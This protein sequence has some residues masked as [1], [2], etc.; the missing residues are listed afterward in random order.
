M[1][2]YS[3]LSCKYHTNVCKLMKPTLCKGK[4]FFLNSSVQLEFRNK[5]KSGRGNQKRSV[6]SKRYEKFTGGEI[7]GEH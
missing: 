6:G 7:T 3:Y 1:I 2:K 4:F 5:Q